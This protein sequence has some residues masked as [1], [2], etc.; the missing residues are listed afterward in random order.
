MSAP[1]GATHQWTTRKGGLRLLHLP[2]AVSAPQVGA[3]IVAQPSVGDDPLAVETN[4]DLPFEDDA[5]YDSVL[6]RSAVE[7]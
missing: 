7:S 4:A 6:H 2:L 5:H 1:A 3:R